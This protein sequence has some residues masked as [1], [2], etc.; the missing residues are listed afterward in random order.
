M[1]NYV[2]ISNRVYG[3][4]VVF[5]FLLLESFFIISNKFEDYR[6]FCKP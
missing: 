5:S 2:V 3:E 4:L 1:F 6:Q